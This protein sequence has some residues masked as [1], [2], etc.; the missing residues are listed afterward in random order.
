MHI[1]LLY[2]KYIYNT[3]HIYVR[4]ER[5]IYTYIYVGIYIHMLYIHISI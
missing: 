3:I 4:D 1:I 5:F 2:F